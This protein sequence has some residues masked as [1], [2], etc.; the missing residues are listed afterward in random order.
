MCIYVLGLLQLYFLIF[1]MCSLT[2]L[3]NYSANGVMKNKIDGKKKVPLKISMLDKEPQVKF[4]MTYKEF[5]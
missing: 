4:S 5:C 1:F 3:T 2:L